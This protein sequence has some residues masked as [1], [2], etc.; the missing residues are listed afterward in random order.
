MDL[1]F[2]FEGGLRGSGGT[3]EGMGKGRCPGRSALRY[4]A[5]ACDAATKVERGE[6]PAG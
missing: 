1:F 2:F 6:G 4:M 3:G 5:S